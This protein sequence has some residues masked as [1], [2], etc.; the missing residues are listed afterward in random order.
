MSSTS[1]DPR[2]RPTLPACALRVAATVC[3]LAGVLCAQGASVVLHVAWPQDGSGVA[4]GPLPFDTAPV[5]ASADGVTASRAIEL[6]R[7][8]A[9][10]V[11]QAGDRATAPGR[12]ERIELRAP[13]AG[14]VAVATALHPAVAADPA[15]LV[16]AVRIGG[17]R[18]DAPQ[19]AVVVASPV[20]TR[21]RLDYD[22]GDYGVVL[23]A[24]VVARSP[25]V[26]WAGL[27][28]RRDRLPAAALKVE[29]LASQPLAP[30]A[31]RVELG[32]GSAGIV[33]F[34]MACGAERPPVGGAGWFLPDSWPGD[35][36]DAPIVRA[37]SGPGF[38]DADLRRP[39]PWAS[40][41][42]AGQ[43]GTQ[44]SL[45]AQFSIPIWTTADPRVV[46]A[47][48]ANGE[49]WALRP[50]HVLEPGSLDPI[51]YR[52]D[53][54]DMFTAGRQF[55]CDVERLGEQILPRY[56]T[57]GLGG[58]IGHDEQHFA[59]LP[60]LAAYACTGDPALG[61]VVRSDHAIDM[62]QKR[63]RYGWRSAGRGEGRVAYN[64]L[65]SALLLDDARAADVRAH[66]LRRL[67]VAIDQS[68][69][70]D[71]PASA[72]VRPIEVVS[73]PRLE[74]RHPAWKPWEEAQF[75][76]S[77]WLLWR[78]TDDPR[79]LDQAWRSGLAVA[80][81]LYR[82][83]GGWALPYAC[84]QLA[85]GAA[86]PRAQ[87]RSDSPL[88]HRSGFPLWWSGC[89]LRGFL[90]AAEA[91][92]APR[93]DEEQLFV[94]NARAALQWLDAQSPNDF[95]D[96]HTALYRT[97]APG[98][99]VP[100][101]SAVVPP[102]GEARD[103]EARDRETMAAAEP[104]PIR[105]REALAALPVA[106]WWSR[107]VAAEERDAA[108]ARA[109]TEP[110]DAGALESFCDALHESMTALATRESLE[111]WCLSRPAGFAESL[112]ALA[113][114]QAIATGDASADASAEAV[115]AVVW[116]DPAAVARAYAVVAAVGRE[117]LRREAAGTFTW[118]GRA[119][120]ARALAERLLALG[121][122]AGRPLAELGPDT[123]VAQLP[124]VDPA[125][126]PRLA[127]RLREV[128]PTDRH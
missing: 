61:W 70:K 99:V 47:L 128:V 3:W 5:L 100:G 98:L 22:L 8:D 113:V 106:D 93:T 122:L 45:G 80:S 73:D 89:G 56:Q 126:Y 105:L 4:L 2:S 10:Y 62:L 101:G 33:R 27:V 58:R 82:E 78:A 116:T 19:R 112:H 85:D 76:W 36:L 28:L 90:F 71:L 57:A 60:L 9:I 7:H 91:R 86:I 41:P 64:M 115:A 97:P 124:S 13:A 102:A 84:T 55:H 103:R 77:S 104:A 63:P 96:A 23:W 48:L 16:P 111:M 79:A 75:A 32:A 50:V 46:P 120:A 59:D 72:P 121:Q 40:A 42:S 14:P 94:D 20:L 87:L 44:P 108:D 18:Q 25:V 30:A 118:R 31:F 37:P 92:T 54:G 6:G 39:F 15:A 110:W 107:D 35:W 95:V 17:A 123:P 12:I 68:S 21:W 65:A 53:R 83:G 114:R 26:D 38:A 66:L 119:R 69:T 34:R 1:P 51:D 74:C 81:V 11:L 67:E 125:R 29:I 88:V 109:A 52:V 127:A 43:G 24:T 49:D 117:L